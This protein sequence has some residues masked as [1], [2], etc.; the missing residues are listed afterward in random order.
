MYQQIARQAL[1]PKGVVL[2]MTFGMDV[3]FFYVSRARRRWTRHQS[4]LMHRD[5][6]QQQ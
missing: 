5:H 4:T 3:F 1:T 6:P 2:M